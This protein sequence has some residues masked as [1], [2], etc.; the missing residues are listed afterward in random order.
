VTLAMAVVGRLK[1]TKVPVY[2]LAQYL[3]AFVG[4]ASVYLVY[5]GL[6]LDFIALFSQDTLPSSISM[7]P[8]RRKYCTFKD[9]S[10]HIKS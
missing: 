2:W 10:K 7:M 1:W 3:G 9:N 5:Y 4:A 8:T 6:L